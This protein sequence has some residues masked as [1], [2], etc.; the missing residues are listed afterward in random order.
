MA[1]KTK[2]Y[3]TIQPDGKVEKH[4]NVAWELK[5]LQKNVG[6]GL[7]EGVTFK[8][9]GK[10]YRGWA[11]EEGLLKPFPINKKASYYRAAY[12]GVNKDHPMYKQY[13][14]VGPII[15][16]DFRGDEKLV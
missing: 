4:E 10:N 8:I 16:E 5:D 15:V 13:T 11:N 6:G 14:L 3:I 9:Q 2:T 1:N 12:Y 7:I